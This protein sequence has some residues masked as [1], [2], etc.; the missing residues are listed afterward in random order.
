MPEVITSFKRI[1]CKYLLSEEQK[2]RLL[3]V[4]QEHMEFDPYCQNGGHYDVKNIYFDDPNN[5]VIRDSMGKPLYKAKLRLRAY[6]G[7][8]APLFFLELKKKFKGEVFKRRIA[9]NDGE[10]ADFFSRQKLPEPNGDY[11]HDFV[12]K[13]IANWMVQYPGSLPQVV[14]QYDRIAM[15][16]KAD[17]PYLRVTIDG[18]I[19]ARRYNLDILEEGGHSLLGPRQYLLEAKIVSALPYWFTKALNALK[20]YRVTSSKYGIEYNQLLEARLKVR[21][22]ERSVG[23]RLH[24]AVGKELSDFFTKDLL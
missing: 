12:L 20:I 16:N 1:E 23:P 14:L 6:G 22:A 8:D 7:G 13:E 17:E 2:D 24:E 21:A 9:L 5:D 4:L 18:N 10:Y 11:M 3:K 15:F 19:T